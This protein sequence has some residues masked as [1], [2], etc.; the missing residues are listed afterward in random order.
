MFVIAGSTR[1]VDYSAQIQTLSTKIE[2]LTSRVEK[3]EESAAVT[4]VPSNT[5]KT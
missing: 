1:S 4:P 2:S 3:V 5:G